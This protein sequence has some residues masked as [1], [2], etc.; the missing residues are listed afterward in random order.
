METKY[1]IEGLKGLGLEH[2]KDINEFFDSEDMVGVWFS[3]EQAVDMLEVYNPYWDETSSGY[4][5]WL[6]G[7]LAPIERFLDASGWYWEP[8]DSG[9]IHAYPMED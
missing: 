8:Y 1:I 3:G 9:T 5:I 4:T 2:V 7:L 6:D